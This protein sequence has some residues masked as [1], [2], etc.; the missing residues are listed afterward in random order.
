MTELD[1]TKF[2]SNAISKKTLPSNSI[3]SKEIVP[4]NEKAERDV[5]KV[6]TGRVIKRRKSLGN[7][8]TQMLFGN[9]ARSV[10]AYVLNDVL[11][12]AAKNTIQE[13]VSGGIEML[14]FGEN[15]GSGRHN[16]YSRRD[17]DRTYISYGKYF[18][19]R[20]QEI[21]RARTRHLTPNKYDDIV[22]ETR[23]EA[24]E[25]LS[26]LVDLMENYDVARVSDFCELVGID[27]DFSDEKYG[28]TNLSRA[29]VS[30]VRDGY[31]II[32]PK[33]RPID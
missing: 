14:L 28:W 10:A 29:T 16:N 26:N 27:S 15:R 5:K 8:I 12:P 11:V 6:V 13:M 23:A 24:E 19:D 21:L 2:P 18:T 33:P 22:L 32:L 17:R 31:A 9:D 4:A 7:A 20:D 1:R 3:K 30:R 25:V